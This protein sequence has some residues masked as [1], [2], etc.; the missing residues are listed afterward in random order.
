VAIPIPETENRPEETQAA[1]QVFPYLRASGW[2]DSHLARSSIGSGG[3]PIPW[4]RYSAIDFLAER[5]RAEHAVFEFGSGN[6]TL[7]WAERAASVT[8]VEHDSHWA[9]Q[10][11]R[12]VPEN[13]TLLEISLEADGGYCRTA[14]RVGERFDIVVIDGRDRVNCALHCLEALTDD[15]VIVWDDS[16]RRRY[17]PGLE[18]L[19]ERGFRRLRF[20]GLGPIAANDGETS[21]LYR[22]SNCF[23]I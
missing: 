8:A 16:Q 17:R 14:R 6:S 13:V 20:T 3:E 23:G 15:G 12:G 21:V 10:V 2:I 9:G 4:Y 11:R 5:V 19:A 7:W 18:F 22:P 1:L